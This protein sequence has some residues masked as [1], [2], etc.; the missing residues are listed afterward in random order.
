[1]TETL[2]SPVN[3]TNTDGSLPR[4]GSSVWLGLR[5]IVMYSGGICS[6]ATAKRVVERHGKENVA[7]LFADTM[8]EDEDL[9]RFLDESADNVGVPLIKIADGRT[10][11]EIFDDVKALGSTR[12][13]PCSRIL[14]REILDRWVRDNAPDAVQHF[15]LDWTETH[16]LEKLR[17]RK[18]PRKVEAYM[19]E[20]PHMEKPADRSD[21]PWRAALVAQGVRPYGGRSDGNREPE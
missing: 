20:A 15:G 9:Y 13:D 8:M 14:K 3:A 11:W 18:A 1:M 17:A 21:L 16:R 10:P 6:W 12:M 5:E 2:Q 7:L 4:V 19:T